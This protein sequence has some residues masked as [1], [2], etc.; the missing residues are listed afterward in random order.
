MV[1]IM[2]Q[3]IS[4]RVV[5]FGCGGAG[6]PAKNAPGC[7]LDVKAESTHGLTQPFVTIRWTITLAGDPTMSEATA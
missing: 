2:P 1:I 5:H 3:M 6:V 4:V 7:G